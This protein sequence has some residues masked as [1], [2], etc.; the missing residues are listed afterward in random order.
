MSPW[1][2][3]FWRCKGGNPAHPHCGHL[4]YRFER[5]CWLCGR[6]RFPL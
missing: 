2:H 3:F 4:N 6:E 5:R 1:W